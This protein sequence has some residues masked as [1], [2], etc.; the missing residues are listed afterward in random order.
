MRRVQHCLAF[1]LW[2]FVSSTQADY[3]LA[4]YSTTTGPIEPQLEFLEDRS[5]ELTLSDVL[6][7]GDQ[8]SS[9]DK[10]SANFGFTS[11]AYWFATHLGRSAGDD[12]LILRLSY[13][14]LDRIDLYLKFDDGHIE[15]FRAG[16]SYPFSKR[17]IKSRAFV[18]PVEFNSMRQSVDVYV[19]VV[20]TSSMQVPMS[21]WQPAAFH[22]YS[23]T[24]QLILGLYYGLLMAIFVYNALLALS[25]R[26]PVYAYYA[27]YVVFYG[28]F[29]MCLNGLAFE[30]L[31]PSSTYLASKGTLVFMALSA[32]LATLF[33]REVLEITRRKNGLNTIFNLYIGCCVAAFPFAL[34]VP[35][36][37]AIQVQT[38]FV[39]LG[40]GLFFYAGVVQCKNGVAAARY[41]LL[42]W[43]LFLGGI[44]VYALK[45]Y[46]LL[47]ENVFTEYAIQ[48]GS[49]LEVM[50]LSFAIAH[51]FK[52]MREEKFRVQRESTELL[53]HRVAERTGE[54]KSTLEE[55][56]TANKR[57]EI[58]SIT[59]S[60]SG[61]HNR[62]Y[63]NEKFE[64]L[65]D[66]ARRAQSPISVLMIDIDHFKAVNDNHGH[67]VG[68]QVIVAVSKLI[69]DSIVRVD[70][71]VARYGGEEFV[72]VL[73]G[74]NHDDAIMAA[75]RI[76][77]A[78]ANNQCTAMCEAG[79]VQ[80]C[81]SIGVATETPEDNDD[82]AQSE[83]L[84]SAADAA[85]YSAKRNGRNQV[86]AKD[87][88]SSR[89]STVDRKHG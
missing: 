26:E 9:G 74:T 25:V 11:S 52:V 7:L 41:Y 59:D 88:H 19:R 22:A 84:L 27:L 1:F 32:A 73:P 83:P 8:F 71:L 37:V 42:A 29:Q 48:V 38:A 63:F 72:V 47:P 66:A 62:A 43:S 55:L 30:F 35:Y 81:V 68:D 56:S 86:S 69:A 18:F 40:T 34:L 4:D 82:A 6:E 45:T 89:S 75:E 10:A 46:A 78:V 23:Q 65:W 44:F 2:L 70:D 60:L 21:V 15:H 20:T 28:V 14:L 87:V 3:G 77:L 5:G 64:L 76:R 85:L 51:R 53:E 36:S 24:E 31:W 50:L 58:L 61:V 12:T 33:S 16:D 57:L 49:A 79:M 67:L 80:V 39:I 17:W 54:L 13:P